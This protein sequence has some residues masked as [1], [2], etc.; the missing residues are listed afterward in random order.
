MP[1]LVGEG[2]SG[3]IA[4]SCHLSLGIEIDSISINRITGRGQSLRKFDCG[5]C[6]V[7]GDGGA[8]FEWVAAK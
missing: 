5:A 8:N 7:I 2:K 6:R 3:K 4:N 1:C